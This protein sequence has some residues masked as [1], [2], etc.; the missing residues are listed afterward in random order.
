M[1]RMTTFALAL[2]T[3][4][5]GAYAQNVDGGTSSIQSQ[6]A[7]ITRS[8]PGMTPRFHT[9]TPIP[10][11]LVRS[12]AD[13]TVRTV[14]STAG[15]TE[16]RVDKGRA[17]ISVHHPADKST[18]TVDL[19]G[20]QVDLLKDGLYTFNADTG[21]VRVLRGEADAYPGTATQGKGTKIKEDHELSFAANGKGLKSVEA[22][23]GEMTADLVP[24]PGMQRGYAAGG[25]G[26]GYGPY[27]DGYA[28]YPYPYYPNPYYAW[29]YPYGFYPYGY[30]FGFGIGFGY[31][32]G[33]GGFRGGFRR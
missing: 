27:G 19:P 22:G 17:T 32:G 6:P 4:S 30:P 23:P 11:V 7:P 16:L 24:G 12:D 15:A 29:G 1:Q 10:G 33:F 13:G 8:A 26:P 18:I 21:T 14:S 3:F 5:V 9:L 25:Y 31:Y 28:E 2:A 20:G